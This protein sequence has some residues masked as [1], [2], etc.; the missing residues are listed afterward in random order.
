MNSCTSCG[1]F[2]PSYFFLIVLK[3]AWKPESSVAKDLWRISVGEMSLCWNRRKVE[4]RS[5]TWTRIWKFCSEREGG[6]CFKRTLWAHHSP[7][8]I[9]LEQGG[10]LQ[11]KAKAFLW[12][13]YWYFLHCEDE[14]VLLQVVKNVNKGVWLFGFV[15][16]WL[17]GFAAVW[18]CGCGCG[19]V[20]HACSTKG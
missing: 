14:W 3:S 1:L 6:I 19:C 4:E 15:A 16:L 11:R 9:L 13:N 10:W 5:L 2:P 7:W 12:R 18:L 8:C 20:L 17:C